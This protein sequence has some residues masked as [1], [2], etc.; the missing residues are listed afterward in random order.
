MFIRLPKKIEVGVYHFKC[1]N[2]EDG[3]KYVVT[4]TFK[5]YGNRVTVTEISP[6]R[7][8]VNTA[9]NVTVFGNGF[10]DTSKFFFVCY[11]LKT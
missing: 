1:H 4:N 7:V 8:P 5:I 10:T 3:K 2:N 6:D 9:V 11:I